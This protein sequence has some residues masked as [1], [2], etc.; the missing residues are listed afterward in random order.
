MIGKLSAIGGGHLHRLV[1]PGPS[2][3]DKNLGWF[4]D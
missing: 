2:F 1:T 3:A 4:M